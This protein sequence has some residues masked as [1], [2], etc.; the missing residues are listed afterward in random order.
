MEYASEAQD[1]GV[2]TMM[3]IIGNPLT[4]GITLTGRF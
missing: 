2:G 1:M 4:F 3:A